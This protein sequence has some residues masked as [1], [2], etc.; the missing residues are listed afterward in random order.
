M[1]VVEWYKTAVSGDDAMEVSQ[2]K[3]VLAFAETLNFTKAAANCN[4]S[5]LALAKAI[6]MQ[7]LY[8]RF[9]SEREDWIQAMVL[10]QKNTYFNRL[11][12]VLC[13][14]MLLKIPTMSR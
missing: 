13:S 7:E 8:A 6:K 5:Q 3:C 1:G 9:R 11:R 10:A 4:V 12:P 2:I 14:V